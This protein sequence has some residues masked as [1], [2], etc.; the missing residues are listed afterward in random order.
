MPVGDTRPIPVDVRVLTATN[1]DLD[2]MVRR[3]TFRQDLFFR[4]NVVVLRT[5]PL[6]DRPGDVLALADHFLAVQAALYDEPRKR[7]GP[8]VAA[9]LVGYPWPG[10][11]RELANVM[12]HAHVLAAGDMVEL[13][14]IPVRLATAPAE[15]AVESLRLEDVERTTIAAAL[16]KANYNKAMAGRMLG[17]NIQRLNRRIVRLGIPGARS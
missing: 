12:E 5:P 10:N 9:V 2:E 7:L 14:D 11:V 1:R 6:R 13:T 8:A 3:G 15:P 16:K 4:L 17:I